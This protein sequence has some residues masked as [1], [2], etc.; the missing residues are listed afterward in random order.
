MISLSRLFITMLLILYIPDYLVQF[1]T[2][3]FLQTNHETGV[4]WM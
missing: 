1:P 2:I 4:E 3:R